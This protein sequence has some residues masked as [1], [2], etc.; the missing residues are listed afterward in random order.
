MFVSD[1]RMNWDFILRG[2][3]SR[4]AT[5]WSG[6][7]QEL[8]IAI[9]GIFIV[10]DVGIAGIAGFARITGIAAVLNRDGLRTRR[11]RCGAPRRRRRRGVL[12]VPLL[13]VGRSQSCSYGF[14]RHCFDFTHES[15]F[16]EVGKRSGSGASEPEQFAIEGSEYGTPRE[17]R[18]STATGARTGGLHFEMRIKRTF[19]W[20][21]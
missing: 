17:S 20:F 1:V 12:D 13:R 6:A 8:A 4:R 15:G 11:G 3:T 14:V 18:S 5:W 2:L 21:L 9:R 16:I 19:F 10:R 7:P